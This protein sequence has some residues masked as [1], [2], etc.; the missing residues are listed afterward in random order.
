MTFSFHE[1]AVEIMLTLLQSALESKDGRCRGYTT[2]EIAEGL[3]LIATCEKNKNKIFESGAIPNCEVLMKSKDS[4]NRLFA[5]KVV[6]QLAFNRTIREKLEA[7]SALME[8]LDRL[9]K[10]TDK[11]VCNSARGA[12]W[13]IQKQE[14]EEAKQHTAVTVPCGHIMISY[15]WN[16]Q[17]TMLKVN[18]A[19][20][21]AGIKVWMDVEQMAGSTLQAMAEAVEK[22]SV[23]LIGVSAKYKDSPNCRTEAEYT[24]ELRKEIIPLMMEQNYKPDGW[25][26]AL[27]GAKLWI[28]FSKHCNFEESIKQLIRDINSCTPMLKEVAV[29]NKEY[30]GSLMHQLQQLRKEAPEFFYA[31]LRRDLAFTS[32]N[33]ILQ[34]LR[35]LDK[36]DSV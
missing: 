36:M 15:Q 32:L 16:S 1:G 7:N 9:S 26:G 17:K 3:A 18:R 14:K 33:E 34:F 4:R 2:S 23:V 25:L 27:L 12:L 8:L 20:Q 35:A 29:C 11:E 6:W 10:D 21:D 30:D 22:A 24:F 19:L 5:T 13:V 31:S 28:D